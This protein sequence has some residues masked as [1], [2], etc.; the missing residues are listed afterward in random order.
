M[1][2]YRFPFVLRAVPFCIPGILNFDQAYA[3][4]QLV[5][6]GEVR[7]DQALKP[8]L[9][10]DPPVDQ[11][12]DP[13]ILG[14]QLA[15]LHIACAQ[16]L[17]RD[18]QRG[19]IEQQ[20]VELL[21]LVGT[22]HQDIRPRL[23]QGSDRLDHSRPA[24]VIPECGCGVRLVRGARLFVERREEAQQIS[25]FLRRQRRE[26][27]RLALKLHVQHLRARALG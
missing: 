3:V 14:E 1:E 18:R 7:T 15:L 22:E 25:L 5:D 4:G 8:V 17:L 20:A 9:V 19:G 11:L 2:C 6:D 23:V 13:Q 10:V 21:R 24:V 26:E 16:Q 27:L 12:V